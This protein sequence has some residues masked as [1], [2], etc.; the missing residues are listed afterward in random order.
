VA[1]E[2][3]KV[4]G[5]T[6]WFKWLKQ[7]G[8][9][10]SPPDS[11]D[12]SA[13]ADQAAAGAAGEGRKYS[14]A[15]TWDDPPPLIRSRDLHRAIELHSS[16]AGDVQLLKGVLVAG[17]V[18]DIGAGERYQAITQLG[19]LQQRVDGYVAGNFKAS[20]L[21]WLKPCMHGCCPAPVM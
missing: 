7:V 3:E 17:M 11:S 18:G 8:E 19:R 12:G 9:L 13:P 5:D 4:H 2:V 20:M 1:A 10:P 21:F 6:W 16:Q 15:R 14:M